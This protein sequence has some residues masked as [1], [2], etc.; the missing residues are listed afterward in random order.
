MERATSN[1]SYS[2]VLKRCRSDC[3]HATTPATESP[4]EMNQCVKTTCKYEFDVVIDVCQILVICIY[5]DNLA[6]VAG[7]IVVDIMVT[8]GEVGMA[9]SKTF[10]NVGDTINRS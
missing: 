2:V 3:I 4:H 9:V 5:F 8:T 10:C 6:T 7:A 1:P